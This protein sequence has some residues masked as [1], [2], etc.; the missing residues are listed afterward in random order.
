MQITD[1]EKCMMEWI[2]IISWVIEYIKANRNADCQL[3]LRKL[4]EVLN[5]IKSFI[6]VFFYKKQ[7]VAEFVR[8]TISKIVFKVFVV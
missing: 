8:E 7:A 6:S 1:F 2:T 5:H 3:Y 4:Y